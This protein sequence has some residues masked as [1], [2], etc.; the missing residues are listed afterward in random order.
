MQ[1]EN[2]TGTEDLGNVEQ[3]REILFG[4][5][6]RELSKKIE[7]LE[8]NIKKSFDEIEIKI[9]ANQKDFNQKLNNEVDLITKKIKNI[10]T[11]YQD[12]LVD[13]KDNNLKQEKRVQHNIDKLNEELGIK[14]EQ[15]RKEQ[16]MNKDSMNDGL[17]LLK[18]ELSKFIEDTISQ[19]NEDKFSK[20][21]AAEVL[22]EAA[23]KIKGNSIHKDLNLIKEVEK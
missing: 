20:D 13:L 8:L 6:A 9:E 5:Q 23:L 11:T 7:K 3:I 15:L 19:I 10:T 1:E 14:I 18:L 12:E 17:S 2:L 22:M 4:S 21:F 16:N